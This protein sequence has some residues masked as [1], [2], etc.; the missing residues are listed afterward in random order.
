[1]SKKACTQYPVPSQ[2]GLL[3]EL[4]GLVHNVS[5]DIHAGD[6]TDAVSTLRA[7][8]R[9]DLHGLK[10]H[11]LPGTNGTCKPDPHTFYA[12]NFVRNGTVGGEYN[13]VAPPIIPPRAQQRRLAELGIAAKAL[14]STVTNGNVVTYLPSANNTIDGLT[15]YYAFYSAYYTQ[16]VNVFQIPTGTYTLVNP[17]A[18]FHMIL[19]CDSQVRSAFTID[20]GGSTFI[21]SVRSPS[22]FP[23]PH[24]C[25]LPS[26]VSAHC[27]P[28]S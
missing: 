4:K 8:L 23:A 16:T 13:V 5:A 25:L 20:F 24:A 12:Y 26:C 28:V 7:D 22:R 9:S 14:D 11:P 21:F 18:G 3:G 27:R 6:L 2:P 17:F 10:H 19:P 1:M 15:F